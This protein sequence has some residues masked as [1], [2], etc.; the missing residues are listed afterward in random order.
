VSC[1][2]S[3]AIRRRGAIFREWLETQVLSGFYGRILRLDASIAR[4]DAKLHAPNH[5]PINDTFIA[6]AALVNG[7]TVATRNLADF[8]STCGPRMN[9]WDVQTGSHPNTPSKAAAGRRRD[10]ESFNRPK[11]Q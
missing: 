11:P 7:M 4:G 1:W 3:G 6:K 2:P 8:A 10:Q 5:Q 9:S